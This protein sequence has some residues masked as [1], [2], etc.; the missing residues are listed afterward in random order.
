MWIMSPGFSPATQ[1]ERERAESD[2]AI[3][4]SSVEFQTWTIRE[5]FEA[6]VDFDNDVH[7]DLI[8]G[9]SKPRNTFVTRFSRER[10]RQKE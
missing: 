3:V 5:R 10:K 7:V 1:F 6:T 9:R 8:A 4:L 2:P